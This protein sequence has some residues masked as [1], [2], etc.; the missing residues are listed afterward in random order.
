MTDSGREFEVQF[1]GGATMTVTVDE[2]AQRLY[3]GESPFDIAAI[4]VQQQTDMPIKTVRG[5]G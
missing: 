5:L 1:E 3:A 2:G 4:I